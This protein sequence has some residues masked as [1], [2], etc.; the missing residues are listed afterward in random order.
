MYFLLFL[1]SI[2]HALVFEL[3]VILSNSTLVDSEFSSIYY[4]CPLLGYDFWCF[5][6]FSIWLGSLVII[7]EMGAITSYKLGPV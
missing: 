5:G 6:H 7:Y 3:V 4:P 2:E 1:Q